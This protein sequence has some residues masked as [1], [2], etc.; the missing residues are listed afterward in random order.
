M[1]ATLLCTEIPHAFQ[2]NVLRKLIIR[3]WF[4]FIH[5]F[6]QK[7]SFLTESLTLIIGSAASSGGQG[8][9]TCTCFAYSWCRIV[10][11]SVLSFIYT[12]LMIHW[13]PKEVSQHQALVRTIFNVYSAQELII[14]V[15]Y[16]F[17]CFYVGIIRR[18][19]S[20]IYIYIYI[21]E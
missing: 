3:R 1:F 13:S 17:Y 18:G 15:D 19:T 21:Y 16:I 20:S 11:F 9:L 4:Y 14:F 8:K 10:D 6:S 7:K 5:S 2:T 12:L